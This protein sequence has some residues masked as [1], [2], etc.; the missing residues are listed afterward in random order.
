MR[1]HSVCCHRL[2]RI[3]GTWAA[4]LSRRRGNY[5][6][7]HRSVSQYRYLYNF[8]LLLE[9]E[10]LK[11][12]P[13]ARIFGSQL[14][15]IRNTVCYLWSIMYCTRAVVPLVFSSFFFQSKSALVRLIEDSLLC[16]VLCLWLLPGGE[17]YRYKRTQF[18]FSLLHR[19]GIA[20]FGP[21]QRSKC[22]L[23]IPLSLP[24]LFPFTFSCPCPLPFSFPFPSPSPFLCLLLPFPVCFRLPL[25]SPSPPLHLYPPSLT[26]ILKKVLKVPE[27]GFNI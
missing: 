6:N 25:L 22:L 15:W 17:K 26:Q 16:L 11:L 23:L 20:L 24:S 3:W 8:C 12:D 7:C 9:R 5:S 21:E 19:A 1:E 2:R 13:Q 4:T 14:L 10:E 27:L 18:F